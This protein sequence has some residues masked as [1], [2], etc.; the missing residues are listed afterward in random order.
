MLLE[1]TGAAES[2]ESNSVTDI[3][4]LAKASSNASA[5]CEYASYQE[6]RFLLYN[7]NSHCRLY[8][9]SSD[10]LQTIHIP[11]FDGTITCI[12]SMEGWLLLSQNSS[13]FFF[14][15][16]SRARIDLPKFPHSN[17]SD[18]V[19]AFSSSPASPDCVVCVIKHSN[20]ITLEVNML[21]R[22]AT[23]W[24]AH[25]HEN[26]L[27]SIT[28]AIFYDGIFYFLDSGRSL[29]T[30]SI[31]SE[32]FDD[33]F[34]LDPNAPGTAVVGTLPFAYRRKYFSD[35]MKQKMGL[36]NGESLSTCGTL[37]PISSQIDRYIHNE[38][39]NAGMKRNH[40]ATRG[41]GSIL[42]S[43]RSHQIRA[44]LFKD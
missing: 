33:Y 15:P 27:T 2:Q 10:K 42:D 36:E 7:D 5:E 44:G 24:I 30:L 17:L 25:K 21:K 28:G 38:N 11:E 14:C 39:L 6:P 43:F 8:T 41:Y 23:E 16:F 32:T 18:H 40:V 3:P 37:V 35:S 26:R 31:D 12:A 29:I 22:G 13:V 19:A 1:E 4:R 20:G 34:I 9:P